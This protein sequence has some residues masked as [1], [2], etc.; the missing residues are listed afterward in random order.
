MIYS[1]HYNYKHADIYDI[2][3]KA[4]N[5]KTEIITTEKDYVKIPAEF[6]NKIRYLDVEL[7]INNENDLLNFLKEKLNEKN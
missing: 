5:L 6:K 2:L 7:E 1:D 4:K 3:E